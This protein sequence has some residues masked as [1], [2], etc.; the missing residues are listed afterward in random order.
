[1]TGTWRARGLCSSRPSGC[2]DIQY[3]IHQRTA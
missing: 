3:Y 1:L 2:D